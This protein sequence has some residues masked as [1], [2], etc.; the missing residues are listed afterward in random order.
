M[1][2]REA[3]KRIP[4]YVSNCMDGKE[5]E[6]FIAHIRSCKTCY[7]ELETFYTIHMAVALLDEGEESSFNF[8]GK[9]EKD[10]QE[11]ERMLHFQRRMHVLMAVLIVF[12]AGVMAALM[13]YLK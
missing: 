10:L 4:D 12:F 9:L 7:E 2:C 6:A 1:D 5:Q 11:K 13:I 8:S 3:L